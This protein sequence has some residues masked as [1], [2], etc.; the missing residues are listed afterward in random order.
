MLS[1][2]S[3]AS[4]KSPIL[5]FKSLSRSI[6]LALISLWTIRGTSSSWRNVRPLAVPK[7]IAFL[8]SQSSLMVLFFAPTNR[9]RQIRF[10]VPLGIWTFSFLFML[11]VLFKYLIKH[12]QG[13]Y[14]QRIHRPK[15]GQLL[16]HSTQ[17]TQQG[18]DA[19]H[20]I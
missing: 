1:G 16:E 18:L 6:L 2:K 7:Q 4:P 8:F 19:E 5:A 14:S 3:L 13:C 9:R 17:A 15:S 12:D 20:L 11:K 10:V